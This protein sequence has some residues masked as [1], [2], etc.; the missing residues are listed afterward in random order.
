[1]L[2]VASSA[3][4][5]RSSRPSNIAPKHAPT[6]A[7]RD[8]DQPPA[9]ILVN[10]FEPNLSPIFQQNDQTLE[11]SFSS[12]SRP[13]FAIKV[14]FFS[15]F[16]DLQDS[17]TFAPLGTQNPRKKNCQIFFRFFNQ[18]LQKI[19]IFQQISSNFASIRMKFS[20]NFAENLRKC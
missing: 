12:V 17:H 4:T 15:I 20:R 9:F 14:S 5:P 13:I 7:L 16:R 6:S 19:A 10:R 1:M 8:A 11:G 2:F 3:R 18:N